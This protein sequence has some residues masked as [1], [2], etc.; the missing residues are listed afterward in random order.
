LKGRTDLQLEKKATAKTSKLRVLGTDIGSSKTNKIAGTN[1]EMIKQA[2]KAIK[3]LHNQIK[4]SPKVPS[5]IKPAAP[6]TPPTAPPSLSG[7]GGGGVGSPTGGG[8][9]KPP[10]STGTWSRNP[11]PNPVEHPEHPAPMPQASPAA[12]QAPAQWPANYQGAPK[13]LDGGGGGGAN[14]TADQ[15]AEFK[16]KHGIQ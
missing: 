14:Y 15:L 2:H 5:S 4:N 3:E 1:T 13:T 10:G 6:P 9:A 12:P 16:K 7:G 8:G 11:R